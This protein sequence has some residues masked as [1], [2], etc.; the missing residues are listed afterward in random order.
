MTRVSIW[1]MTFVAAV[2]VGLMGKAISAQEKYTVIVP[3]GLA[4]A[5]FR[6]Y[7]QWRAVAASQTK[8]TIEVILANPAMIEAYQSGIPGNGKAFPD[9]S[10][11]AK[12]HW[13]LKQSTESPSPTTI[14]DTLHD[15]D[16]IERDSKKFS[17]TGGWGY[18]QF[19]Y[20][21]ASD[22]FSPQGTGHDCGY[23]CHTLV[24]AKDYIFTAYPKR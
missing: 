1:L 16:F 2:L 8:E 18:A 5:E 11:I 15:V 19:N 22:T 14:P 23:A 10:K 6:G 13:K 7:E 17:D 24:K 9:G 4:F 20:D 3:N 21:T 12:I